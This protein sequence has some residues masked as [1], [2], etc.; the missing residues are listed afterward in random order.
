M[1]FLVL[2][3]FLAACGN[4]IGDECVV[5]SD[6][7]PNG[8]RQCDVSSISGYCTIA[9]CDVGTCPEEATCVR[10]FTGNFSNRDCDHTVEDNGLP[11]NDKCTFDE[12]CALTNKCVARNSEIRFCMRKCDDQGDCREGYE[13]RDL[14]LMA[15]HGGEPVL[16]GGTEINEQTAPKFCASALP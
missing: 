13:C 1:R 8:D 3:A 10:F 15:A 2:C 9:G 6:C 14:A 7:S 11:E 12:L 16:E 4:E 5:S